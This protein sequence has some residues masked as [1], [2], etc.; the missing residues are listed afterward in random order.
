MA[1]ATEHAKKTA[2]YQIHMIKCTVLKTDNMHM[3]TSLIF[4]QT[5]TIQWKTFLLSG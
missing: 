3:N 2:V 1:V 5:P 4:D